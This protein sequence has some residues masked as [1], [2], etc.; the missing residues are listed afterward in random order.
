MGGCA[1]TPNKRIRIRKYF[2]RNGRH[3]DIR[4]SAAAYVPSKRLIDAGNRIADCSVTDFDQVGYESSAADTYKTSE[5]CNP[6]S[7]LCQLQR[8]RSAD[9]EGRSKEE[10][11]FDAASLL[12]SESD[13]DI[14]S[15][16]GDVSKRF[17]SRQRAGLLIPC[18]K[19]T[20]PSAGSWSAVSPTV[21]KLRGINYFRDKQ[22]FP[23]SDHSPYTPIGVD[24]FA[25]SKKVN[26]IAQHLELPLVK[27]HAGVPSLLIVNI[28]LPSY[29]AS[30]LLGD[31]DGEGINLVLYFKVSNNFSRDISPEFQDSIKKLVRNDME[32]IKGFAK[33]S[34][35]PFR[36][37]LK[38]LV[39]I[40]NPEDLDLSSTETKF[41]QAYHDKP[42]LSRPQHNFFEG[43]NY[44]EID[45]DIHRFSYI[46]RKGLEAFRERLKYA[47][48]DLGLTIQAQK[49]EELP[50][51]VLCCIQL[52]K[53]D[54][55]NSGRVPTL[56]TTNFNK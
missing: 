56:M 47:T 55:V 24:I 19:I 2:C 36:E 10:I 13:D 22:K 15:S 7:Q 21:F 54:L 52:N 8:E 33:D 18:S 39:G 11:W 3:R 38:I 23:A 35:V 6:S 34:I 31:S 43:P 17:S 40:A 48:L 29:P 9:N 16:R 5:I 30:M 44:F 1:S 25:S 37:R 27:G 28:Q 41:I 50:E 32:K 53:I 46:S 51:Q 20:K 45:L 42:V 4:S 12:E 26:H 14:L 49:P